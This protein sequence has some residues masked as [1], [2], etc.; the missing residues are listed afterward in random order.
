MAD[1]FADTYSHQANPPRRAHRVPR[2]PKGCD[3][4]GRHP[5]AAECCTE[6]GA[7]DP[8]PQAGPV[9]RW[10]GQ[11]LTPEAAPL[12]WPL[13]VLAA[14]GCAAAVAVWWPA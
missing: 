4:Q 3:Q 2:I 11:H 13:A 7:D 8:Q 6:V 10:F 12:L 9:A 1:D 5:E 14:V